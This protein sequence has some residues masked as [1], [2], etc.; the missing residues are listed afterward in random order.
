MKTGAINYSI[1]A[2]YYTKYKNQNI[3]LIDNYPNNI[4]EMIVDDID[5]FA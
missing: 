4:I 5:I 3:K 2:N 1:K